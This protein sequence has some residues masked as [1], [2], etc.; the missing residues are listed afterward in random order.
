MRLDRGSGP[1]VLDLFSLEAIDNSPPSF[2]PA[3]TIAYQSAKWMPEKAYKAVEYF[4]DSFAGGPG[5]TEGYLDQFAEMPDGP[6]VH[7]KED[8]LDQITGR[9]VNISDT[10][11]RGD[12]TRSRQLISI[13]LVK[14]S[15]LP[16]TV[17]RVLEEQGGD[18]VDER[19]F[20]DTTVYTF[21]MPSQDPGNPGGTQTAGLAAA[22]GYLH[23]ATD[24]TLL[25]DALRGPETSL[26]ETEN[27]KEVTADYPRATLGLSVSDTAAS[28]EQLWNLARTEEA[29]EQ[30]LDATD[31]NIDLSSLPEFREVSDAFGITGTYTTRT[32]RGVLINAFNRYERPRD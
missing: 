29:R 7:V 12:Q 16:E 4:V 3:E 20:R 1:S 9:F 21:E 11:G 17:A 22:G 27:Y 10:V 32:D 8:V 18:N 26:G 23:F 13:E 19:S 31:G 24:V 6:G 2:V 5:T 30:V 14:N 25:E 28:L 15:E